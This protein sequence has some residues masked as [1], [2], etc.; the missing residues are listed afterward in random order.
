MKEFIIIKPMLED[1]NVNQS[2]DI[3]ILSLFFNSTQIQ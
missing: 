1:D 2:E 3:S